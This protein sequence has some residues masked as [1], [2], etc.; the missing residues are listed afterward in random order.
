MKKSSYV[1]LI[2]SLVYLFVL[3]GYVFRFINIHNNTILGLSVTALFISISE[4][5]NKITILRSID[6]QYQL[7]IQYTVEFLDKKINDGFVYHPIVNIRNVKAS[8]ESIRNKHKTPINSNDYAHNLGNKVLYAFSQGCFVIGISSFIVT[9]FILEE[10]AAGINTAIITIAAFAAMCFGLFIDELIQSKQ[11]DLNSLLSDKHLIIQNVYQD[12][13]LCFTTQMY[14][15]NDI[16]ANTE[17]AINQN[18]NDNPM[19]EQ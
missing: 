13:P 12:F 18:E 7:S 15:Q 19:E 3:V 16:K 2:M 8:I 1:F 11:I 6:N 9:P 5:L 4:V 14:Y 17:I 10:V